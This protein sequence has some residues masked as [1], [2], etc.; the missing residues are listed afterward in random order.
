[1][2]HDTDVL[3]SFGITTDCS[4][5]P[6][7]VEDLHQ[8]ESGEAWIT[9]EKQLLY[10]FWVFIVEISAA[11]CWSQSL[12]SDCLPNCFP[13][14]LDKRPHVAQGHMDYQKKLWR[15]IIAAEA[16][17]NDPKV[18]KRTKLAV[19]QILD[20]I[21]WN[22]I[23]LARELC[24]IC[25]IGNWDAKHELIQEVALAMTGSPQNTKYDLEDGFAHLASLSK[26]WNQSSAMNK[27]LEL[28]ST[29]FR[30]DPY[31]EVFNLI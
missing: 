18:A 20:D 13:A 19:K 16:L 4:G 10:D 9:T 14:V 1:M 26:V 31:F 6:I 7:C 3:Q 28:S 25:S 23:Q 29:D 15:A 21:A 27:S 12:F 5:P 11:R 30:C 8:S 24:L 2:L 17:V 22:N